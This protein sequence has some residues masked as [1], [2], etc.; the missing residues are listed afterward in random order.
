M[1]KRWGPVG[2]GIAGGLLAAFLPG[3]LGPAALVIAALLAG[4]VLPRAPMEAAALFVLP[5]LLIG[6]GRMILDDA[7]DAAGAFAVG[8]VMAVVFAAIFTHVGAGMALRR[9]T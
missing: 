3:A 4:W 1:N 6:V 5:T 8:A 9:E 2:F 7:S